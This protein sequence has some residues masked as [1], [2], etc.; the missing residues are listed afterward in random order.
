VA[1]ECRQTISR[2]DVVAS[3]QEIAFGEGSMAATV[4]VREQRV[5]KRQLVDLNVL[6]NDAIRISA[7]ILAA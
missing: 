3:F 5:V 6:V 4:A 7:V 1:G 2:P